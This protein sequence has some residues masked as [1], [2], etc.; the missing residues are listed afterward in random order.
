MKPQEP[1]VGAVTMEGVT[2][3]EEEIKSV[4]LRIGCKC[5][6]LILE[7]VKISPQEQELRNRGKMCFNSLCKNTPQDKKG[8]K[9]HSLEKGKK[10]G[11]CKKCNAVYERNNYCFWCH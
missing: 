10:I 11:F 6:L 2:K 7:I 1:S 8:W 3:E 5:L 9:E 4:P